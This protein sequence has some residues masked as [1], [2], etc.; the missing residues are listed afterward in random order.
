[1]TQIGLCMIVKNEEK[2]ITRCLESVYKYIS[3]WDICDT[4]STDNTIQ[5]INDF[6]KDKNIPGQVYQHEWK[7]FSINRSLAFQASEPHCQYMFVI[8]AD[9]C[10]ETPLIIPPECSDA[11]S[12]IIQLLEG[13]NVTQKRQQL[14]KSG[15]IWGY[16]GVIHEYPFSRIKK[17][18]LIRE[19]TKIQVRA[20]RGGDRS[21]DPLKYW[22]DAILMES[23]L[24]QIE[25][26][27]KHMLP[28]WQSSLVSRYHYYIS[29]SYYD[30]HHYEK[31]IEWS[32]SRCKFIGFKE[33]V[34]RALL[35]KAR[36][37]RALGRDSKIC[38]KAF[39]ACHDYDP[40]RAEAAFE[41]ANEYERM[42]NLTKAWEMIQK[43]LSTKKPKDKMFIVEDYVYGWGRLQSASNICHKM[44]KYEQAYKYADM[45]FRESTELNQM[46]YANKLKHDNIPKMLESYTVYQPVTTFENTTKN[47]VFHLTITSDQS[48]IEC[49]ASFFATCQDYRDV[50]YWCFSSSQPALEFVK[51]YPFFRQGKESGLKC[52]FMVQDNRQF[53]HKCN[54]VET[55]LSIKNP[56]IEE[57]NQLVQREAE[58]AHLRKVGTPNDVVGSKVQEIIT[59]KKQI[60][61]LEANQLNPKI[62]YLDGT[63]NLEPL[64]KVSKVTNSPYVVFPQGNGIFSINYETSIQV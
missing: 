57:K 18:P 16:E 5:I 14:F 21:K 31:C 59:L 32:D 44:K 43:V 28:H 7:G 58:L 33:E 54:L 30:F 2:I 10:L 3:R 13:Q 40:F 60:A 17:N 22:K 1:M 42:G 41:M 46:A 4:G 38:L 50:D 63:V 64:V 34:Y 23:H 24:K 51:A 27:P 56:K 37:L 25:N 45:L 55:V 15:L 52:T 9:D 48:A 8:D 39:Q 29:Q 36:S 61:A 19:T 6:F 20:S 12:L 53:F 26:I 35:N 62:L 49:M 11:D 47:V